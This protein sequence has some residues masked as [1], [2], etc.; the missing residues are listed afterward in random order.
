MD[1]NDLFYRQQV[2]RSRAD[3]AASDEARQIHEGLARK[4]EEQIAA[5]RKPVAARLLFAWDEPVGNPKL[6]AT[7]AVAITARGRQPD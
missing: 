4:Y 1:L 5:A 2:E 3:A 6:N 7:M